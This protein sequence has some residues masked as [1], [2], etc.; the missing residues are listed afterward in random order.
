MRGL[1]PNFLTMIGDELWVLDAAQP[2][3]AI[4]DPQTGAVQ[5]IRSWPQRPP[6]VKPDD[7]DF[8]DGDPDHH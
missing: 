6:S 5:G 3:G 7:D 1:R 8:Q 2:V 4:L